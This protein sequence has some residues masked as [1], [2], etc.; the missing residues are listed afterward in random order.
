MANVNRDPFGSDD[1]AR[2]ADMEKRADPNN[3]EQQSLL[4]EMRAHVKKVKHNVART[5]DPTRRRLP[6]SSKSSEKAKTLA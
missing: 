4:E 1:A 3:K 2:L 5:A 6:S